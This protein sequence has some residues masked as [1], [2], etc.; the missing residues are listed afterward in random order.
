[1]KIFLVEDV[2][3]VR[4]QIW[5]F[6]CIIPGVEL[7][8]FAATASAALDALRSTVPD[9]VVLDLGLSEGVGQDVLRELGPLMQKIR[10]VV[11]SNTVDHITTRHCMELGAIAVLDKSHQIGELCD[12][13]RDLKSA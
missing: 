10:V 11:F 1:M 6:L 3:S 4:D 9:L 7:A 5:A 13:V 8:G 12:L 2:E